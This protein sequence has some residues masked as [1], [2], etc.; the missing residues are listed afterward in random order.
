MYLQVTGTPQA[1]LLQTAA[2][3]W[4]PAFTYY[5]APGV[6]YLGGDFFFPKDKKADCISWLEDIKEPEKQV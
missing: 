5:F 1:V 6:G 4:H 3:G 2:S